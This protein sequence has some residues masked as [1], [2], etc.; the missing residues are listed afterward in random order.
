[1]I[2]I[3]ITYQEIEHRAREIVSRWAGEGLTSV[4]GVPRGGC[5]PAALV[6][7]GLRL[8]LVQEPTDGTLVIDD[9]VDSGRTMLR[10]A[11][12]PTDAL[13]R[14][15]HSP[16]AAAPS[17]SLIDAWVVFP[18]EIGEEAGPTDAVVRL[19]E[20]IG[21]D[22]TR[23]GLLATPDRV[24][25]SFQEMT[26]GYGQ[27]PA[28]ILSTTFDATYDEMVIVRDLPFSSLCE[29][30]L[31]PF[32]GSAT[33]AYIPSDRVVGLSK[34][35]RLLDCYAHRLQIQEQLTTQLADAIDKYLEP[36]GAAAIVSATHLCMSLRGVRKPAT[37]T[38][39]ALRGALLENPTARAELMDLR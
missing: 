3:T 1:M 22:P 23:D 25:R 2:Q 11:G 18:W 13:F 14:K 8:P 27:D 24:V 28:E 4:W 37:M 21:E 31:L 5:V 15:P 38:T 20:F 16:I 35:G 32:T 10:F 12:W 26:A 33:L 34:L 6:A 17:A 9:L 29:H 19:L 7:S 36:V 39:S 30:H